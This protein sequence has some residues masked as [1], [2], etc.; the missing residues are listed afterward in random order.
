MIIF[1]LYSEN[2]LFK[3]FSQLSDVVSYMNNNN[4]NDWELYVEE[5]NDDIERSGVRTLL[6]K[7]NSFQI[8]NIFDYY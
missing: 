4:R 5:Y 6:Y 2:K 3:S 7:N 8:K 1:Y